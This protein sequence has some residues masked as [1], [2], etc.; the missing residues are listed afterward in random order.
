M[1]V[2]SLK[3]HLSCLTQLYGACQYLAARCH[4]RDLNIPLLYELDYPLL[5]VNKL[6]YVMQRVCLAIFYVCLF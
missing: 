6:H 2:P 1:S 3:Q 4:V 5:V